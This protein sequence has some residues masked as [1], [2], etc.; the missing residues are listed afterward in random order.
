MGL[1]SASGSEA[2]RV[3]S[4][5]RAYIDYVFQTYGT[6]PDSTAQAASQLLS[7]YN[8]SLQLEDG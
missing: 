4:S 1:P 3:Q 2:E 7:K 8:L 6:L 5:A